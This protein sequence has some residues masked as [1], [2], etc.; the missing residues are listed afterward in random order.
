MNSHPTTA[1]NTESK[2]T[3]L[4]T[5]GH[6]AQYNKKHIT[7]HGIDSED[8][9]LKYALSTVKLDVSIILA[10][11]DPKKF[12]V[13]SYFTKLKFLWENLAKYASVTPS[14]M[15]EHKCWRAPMSKDRKNY[16]NISYVRS[17]GYL[18]Q[19]AVLGKNCKALIT[20][21]FGSILK[22]FA[23]EIKR[24]CEEH[25]VDVI[26]RGDALHPDNHWKLTDNSDS[27]HVFRL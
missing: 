15:Q 11:M 6:E 21:S 12:V 13:Q 24:I 18:V 26:R 7:H 14:N 5:T 8:K 17:R 2:T 4:W 3:M 25:K 9:E 20:A 27:I 10:I 1:H 19:N 22:R 23:D 16:V